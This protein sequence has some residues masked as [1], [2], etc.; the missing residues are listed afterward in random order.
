MPTRRSGQS[1]RAMLKS[2]GLAALA[3]PAVPGVMSTP[4]RA[5]TRSSAPPGRSRAEGPDTPKISLGTDIAGSAPTT[6]SP[7]DVVAASARRLRQLGVDHV[8]GGGGP[9]PWDE[10]QLRQTI[11][12]WK[13]NGVT[14]ANLMIAGFPN[15]IYGR[16][17]KDAEIDK[18]IQSIRAAGRAGLPVVEYN[19]YA[20]RAM[21]GYFEEP[22]RAG[23]GRTGFDYATDEGPHTA[24]R[25]RRAH[26]RRDVGHADVLPQGG[27]AGGREGERPARPPS[28]RSTG[29]REPGLRPDHGHHRRTGRSSS[30]S[31]TA[32]R[33]ASPSTAASRVKWAA[34]RSRPAATSAR[35]IASITSTSGTWSCEAVRRLHRGLHRRGRERH[36]RRDEGARR[37]RS[38][39]ASCTRSTRGGST[40]TGNGRP[41]GRSIPVAAA[42][43]ATR[44]MSAIHA[45]CCR[46]PSCPDRSRQGPQP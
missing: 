4:A 3:L 43:P 12:R 5:A 27:G 23:S 35:A 6:V 33:T 19:W 9:I 32:R 31:W 34:I 45:R 17:G 20:H 42:S 8:L 40:T 37:G 26:A 10:G 28:K 24:P 13:A 16:P 38:T 22:G 18:V 15:A 30:R 11:G 2:A 44:S 21:E 14:L 41:S 39:R 1:R 25:R 36:V 29:A 7:D 46:Q